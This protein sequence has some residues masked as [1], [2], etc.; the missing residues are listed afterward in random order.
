LGLSWTYAAHGN[1]DWVA[2]IFAG[3]SAGVVGL[4]AVALL[5]IGARALKTVYARSLAVVA[6]AAI[7]LFGVAFPLVVLGAATLGLVGE[8]VRPGAMGVAAVAQDLAPHER[9]SRGR[10]VRVVATGLAVWWIPLLAVAA[11]RG[12]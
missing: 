7:F 3:L 8:R 9:P 4:V 2:G 10:T 12:S 5:R 6:F 11:W 1:L